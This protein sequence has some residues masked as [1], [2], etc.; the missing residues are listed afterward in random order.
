[1]RNRNYFILCSLFVSTAMN[2]ACTHPKESVVNIQWDN[3]LTLPGCGDMEQNLGLAGA[4]SGKVGGKLIVVGGANFPMGYP[5]E[6]GAKV[7]WPT[8][9]S[10][11]LATKDW[12]VAEHFLSSP[13]G[14]GVS[15]QLPE[16]V[17]CVG[18]C[19]S[20]QCSDRVLL[21]KDE[22]GQLAID[23]VAYPPLPVPLANA[24]GALLNH[25]LYIAGGQETMKGEQSTNHFFMLDLN[26]KSSGW[27]ALETWP[28]SSR[29]YAV[30]VAQNNQLYLFGGRS[31]G[32]D[33]ELTVHT[34]GYA[35][36]PVAGQ[37]RTL[38]GSYPVMAGTAIAYENDKILFLGGVE[39]ILPASAQHPGFSREVRVFHTQGDSIATTLLC[40]FPIPVT[41][42]VVADSDAFYLASGEVQPG[43]RTPQILK[44]KY[45]K[46]L[47]K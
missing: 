15:V 39:K 19:D 12:T 23:S 22:G 8:L 28:G 7:W 27:K 5:W 29:G 11:D 17:L 37:W 26:D 30:C 20:S 2:L 25:K 44:G 34:D 21:I 42:H 40:P 16:G 13:L 43:I 38:S 10:Y 45:Q 31:Y 6:G 14:Y 32:P 18:G 24:A 46:Q 35:F 4:Y 33:E 9:Y 1:M 41:T 3:T 47:I 36:D